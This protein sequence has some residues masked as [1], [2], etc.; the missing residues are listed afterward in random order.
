MRIARGPTAPPCASGSM[1]SDTRRDLWV[2]RSIIETESG[3]LIAPNFYDLPPP[4][5]E[6]ISIRQSSVATRWAT[7][8]DSFIFRRMLLD[9]TKRTICR[10]R[11]GRRS[12]QENARAND[13]LTEIVSPE[14]GGNSDRQ[15]KPLF[16]STSEEGDWQDALV[17]RALL[18]S[19]PV[20]QASILEFSRPYS[21]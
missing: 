19:F 8:R 21:R 18:P 1:R 10:E 4:L 2:P 15:S 9:D 5:G 17:W 7:L 13:L 6:R 3:G 12:R 20:L 11:W 14:P 16:E